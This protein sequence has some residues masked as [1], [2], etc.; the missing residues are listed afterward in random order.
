MIWIS[1]KC[2][3]DSIVTYFEC[4]FAQTGEEL[5]ERSALVLHS[6]DY[7]AQHYREHDE[8][9]DIGSRSVTAGYFPFMN[10]CLVIGLSERSRVLSETGLN[11]VL[12][13]QVPGRTQSLKAQSDRIELVECH[14]PDQIED[15]VRCG[16]RSYLFYRFFTSRHIFIARSYNENQ[17][18]S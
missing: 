13:E 16:D 2:F 14:I 9:K 7:S 15:C 1:I 8:T 17:N 12:R 5:E 3:S 4:R 10:V 6:A 11:Q 18:D